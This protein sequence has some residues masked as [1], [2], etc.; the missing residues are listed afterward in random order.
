MDYLRTWTILLKSSVHNLMPG[1]GAT[2]TDTSLI[3]GISS[4][5]GSS[6]DQDPVADA[7]HAVVGVVVNHRGVHALRL[8][9]APQRRAPD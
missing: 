8:G 9:Q 6:V 2:G 1:L 3:C 7:C 4:D 5:F